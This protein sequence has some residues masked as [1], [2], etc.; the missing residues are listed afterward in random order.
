[1][2]FLEVFIDPSTSQYSASRLCLVVMVLG[3]LPAMVAL[4][5]LGVKL[6]FWSQFAAIVG[7]VAGAYGANS[8][9][10]VWKSWGQE[11]AQVSQMPG[12]EGGLGPPARK[13]NPAP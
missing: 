12:G 4:E 8:A 9:S 6:G 1:M 10:R 5:A 2:R 3:Y 11:E 7:S 13:A